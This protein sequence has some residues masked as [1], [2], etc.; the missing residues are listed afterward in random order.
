MGKSPE[1]T[2]TEIIH[3]QTVEELLGDDRR[4][5]W[6]S[7]KR[8][9]SAQTVGR[10][11]VYSP[12]KVS[13]ITNDGRQ[14]AQSKPKDTSSNQQADSSELSASSNTKH[15]RADYQKHLDLLYQGEGQHNP[16]HINRFPYK[17]YDPGDFTD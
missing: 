6:E 3:G 2:R 11:A 9:L 13:T 8:R 15:K 14:A 12:Q 5:P 10:V 16:K 4:P 1:S 17:E 7:H